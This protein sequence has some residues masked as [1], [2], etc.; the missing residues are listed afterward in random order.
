MQQQ[1]VTKINSKI[2]YLHEVSSYVTYDFVLV[3]TK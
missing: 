3:R 2:Y 1:G